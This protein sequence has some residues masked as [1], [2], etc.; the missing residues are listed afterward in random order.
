MQSTVHSAGHLFLRCIPLAC[1]LSC[2]QL[3]NTMDCN[4]PGFSVHEVFQAKVLWNE[5]PFPS[6]PPPQE[7]EVLTQVLNPCLLH[8]LYWQADS[9]LL[10]QLGSPN[11][12]KVKRVAQLRLTLCDPIYSPWNSPGQ[13]TGVGCHAL[14][15]EI[16]PTQRTNPGLLHYRWILY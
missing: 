10:H 15:Q 9:L 16:F 13:N 14:L 6:H 1:V 8:L 12:V 3:C 11:K 4:P 7:V 5:L 2:V